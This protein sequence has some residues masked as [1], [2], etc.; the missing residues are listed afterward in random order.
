MMREGYFE[1]S[2]RPLHVLVFIAPFLLFYELGLLGILGDGADSLEAHRM[3]VRFFNLFGVV[4][5]HLPS[6]ALVL[7]L[8][9]QH[10]LSRDSWKLQPSVLVRM[11]AESAFLTGPLII[12]V[13]V[14]D[15][16]RS[17]ALVQSISIG[18]TNGERL[19][20]AFGAGLYEEMLFRLLLITLVHFLLSDTLGVKSAKASMIAVVISAIAFA[21]HHDQIFR[22][23]GSL[24]LTLGVFYVLAGLYFGILYLKRGFG[25]VVGVHL[26]YDLLVL[27]VIPA[28][29]GRG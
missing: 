25:I 5:L 13:M 14:L 16:G 18:P 12:L 3:L 29:S 20:L 27:V 2:M 10:I 17:G 19:M 15:P 26:I 23:D 6:I 1:R 9:I 21:W 11:A 4:G 24:N 7:Y 28:F 8:L 22:L